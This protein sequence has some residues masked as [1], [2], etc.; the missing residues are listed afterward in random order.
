MKP[1]D[2]EIWGVKPAHFSREYRTFHDLLQKVR[3]HKTLSFI[4]DS[5]EIR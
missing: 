5:K 1:A 4:T 3:N 2:R